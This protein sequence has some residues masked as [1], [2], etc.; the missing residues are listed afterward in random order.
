M[1]GPGVS[2]FGAG[3]VS[4]LGLGFGVWI[5]V[6]VARVVMVAGPRFGWDGVVA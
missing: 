3:Y 1:L 6:S 2:F 5:R 4:A